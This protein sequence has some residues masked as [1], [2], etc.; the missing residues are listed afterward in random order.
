MTTTTLVFT[1]FFLL[2]ILVLT[3]FSLFLT[4]TRKNPVS[5][6]LFLISFFIN[7]SVLLIFFGADYL[8]ILFLLLYS[9]AISIVLLFVVMFLD[10]KNILITKSTYSKFLMVILF[11]LFFYILFSFVYLSYK[12]ISY[13]LYYPDYTNWSKVL[14]YKTSIE[15]IGIALYNFYL[16]QFLV[17][18]FLLFIVMILIIS[19]IINFNDISKK[20]IVMQQLQTKIYTK[21]SK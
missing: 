12:D 7:I 16:F 10:L 15:I 20:Q 3:F 9:G 2:L 14:N 11:S 6:I 18:G 8:G 1:N 17:I 5:A 21:I 13:F 4:I 19:L